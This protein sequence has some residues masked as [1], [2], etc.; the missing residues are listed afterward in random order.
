LIAAKRLFTKV[1]DKVVQLVVE[2]EYRLI[3]TGHS[4]GAGAVCLLAMLLKSRY[5]SL[6]DDN[7]DNGSNGN[8]GGGSSRKMQVYAFA[9]PPV[10]DHDAA[11]AAQSY[12]TS[13]IH[14]ADLIPRSSLANVAVLLEFLRTIAQRLIQLDK[15]PATVQSTAAFLRMLSQGSH[16]EP[17]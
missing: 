7:V 2:G 12:M 17:I 3:L 14:H 15:A 4:L 13:V 10:L 1:H 16:G 6:V 11:V 5:P 8:G 9:S